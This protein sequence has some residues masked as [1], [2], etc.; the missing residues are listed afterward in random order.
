MA[1]LSRS[2]GSSSFNVVN[3][4]TFLEFGQQRALEKLHTHFGDAFLADQFRRA[5]AG[6]LPRLVLVLVRETKR[7]ADEMDVVVNLRDALRFESAQFAIAL[8]KNRDPCIGLR[9]LY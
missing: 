8:V 1:W 6:F 4:R 9:W 2:F 3:V 7:A 5:G